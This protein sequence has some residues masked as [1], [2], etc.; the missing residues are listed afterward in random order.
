MRA[1]VFQDHRQKEKLAG[2]CPWSV[3]WFDPDGKKKSKSV[4]SKSIAQKLARKIEGQLAAGT[5][6]TH[7]P[8]AWAD[9][10]AEYKKKIA[11]TLSAGTR[12]V[13]E[14]AL[15]AFEAAVHPARVSAIKTGTIDS[16]IAERQ[17]SRGRRPGS[18]KAPASINKELRHL[19]AVL[20]VAS[21][22]GYLPVVP[23]MRMLPEQEKLARYI[24]PEDFASI[25]GAC[26]QADFP[27]G[28]PYAAS[29]WWRALLT[30]SFMTGW[31]ISECLSVRRD[32][33]DM[34]AGTAITR[35]RNNKGK[36]DE[37]IPLHPIVLEHLEKLTSFEPVIFPWYHNRRTLYEEFHR[38]QTAAGIHLTCNTDG[39]HK[40]TDACHLY[41]FHDSRRAFA[42]MNAATLTA[43]ALQ[44]LMR[45][46]S[47]TTTQRYI[48]LAKQ[49]NAAVPAL[50]VPPVL[51]RQK[52]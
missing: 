2:K 14:Q 21:E 13:I 42:T 37:S 32:D 33:V 15:D 28:L 45:H 44:K 6:Q 4:G 30:F 12:V 29:D 27:R 25:Y 17:K 43:D 38:I 46:R 52:A 8:S 23:K 51:N 19:K 9:F 31:R 3:G 26:D 11:S 20:K 24:T 47:Y 10:R 41:G 39:E 22:W 1:W 50:F 34:E 5:Y 18:T 16:F 48:N 40:H 7:K 36:R 35:A 49:V